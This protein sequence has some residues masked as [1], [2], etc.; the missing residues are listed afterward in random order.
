MA[1]NQ[2]ARSGMRMETIDEFMARRRREVENF[3]RAAE[4]AAYAAVGKAIR[5]GQDLRLERDSITRNHI[6][7]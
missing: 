3:G 5:A 6:R 4:D 2:R 1:G 7:R